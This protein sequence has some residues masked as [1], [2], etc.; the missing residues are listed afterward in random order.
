MLYR[1]LGQAEDDSTA[2]HNYQLAYKQQ[3]TAQFG[4]KATNVGVSPL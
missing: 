1:T 2:V 4:S 3:L